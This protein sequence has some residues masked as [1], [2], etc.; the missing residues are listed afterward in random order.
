MAARTGEQ[1]LKGLAAR[2]NDLWVGNEKV[3][4][5]TEHPAFAGAA[6]QMAT[7]FDRQFDYADEC[8]MPDDE[9]GELI[10][11]SHMI[12]RSVADLK[13]RHIGLSRISE[14]TMGLMGRTPD[15]MNVTYAGFAGD[16]AAWSGVD[17]SN[18]R[19]C[20]NLMSFQKRLRRD[21][22]SLTHTIVHPTIDRMH[23]KT[24]TDNR[25]V[26]LH[27]VGETSEG[28]VVRGAR[29]LATLA[30]FADEMA[31][32][33]GHPLP[34][35]AGDEY[36]VSFSVPMDTPGMV[37]LCRDSTT[38]VGVDPFDKPF[39]GG[40]DEQD[41]F[42]IFDDVVVPHD[43]VFIGGDVETYNTAMS[44]N[45]WPNIMQQTTIRALTKME[46]LYGL[47]TRMAEAVNDMNEGTLEM[48]GELAGY[49]EVIRS[50][51]LCAEDHAYDNGNGVFF[52]EGR[53]MHPMR[54]L[55]ATWFP[56]AN[57]IIALIGSHN[58]LATPT[59]AMLDD[60]R[61]RPLLDQYLCGANG[62]SAEDRAAVYRLAWD[63]IGSGLGARNNLYE[64]NYLGSAKTSRVG[65]H[66]KYMDRTRA[67]ALVDDMLSRSHP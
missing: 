60:D 20:E 52:P 14:A 11:V 9:T 10:N 48:L 64:R 26:P 43:R 58:L 31:V 36:A 16:P 41:A 65:A 50:S 1:F 2:Q 51:I 35:G 27:K 55:C 4:D 67:Y 37:L 3:G 25:H 42:V 15:Y 17:G 54:A 59:R 44:T 40:Y 7:V 8:L 28:M 56:R 49:V 34:D 18:A 62:A 33:P 23:D 29:I 39:S 46:F 66:M 22:I 32:Y 45:W 38:M 5:V 13:K 21:D 12:P 53:A 57:E 6:K 19:G 61:L 63:F 47:A 24:F 30:P